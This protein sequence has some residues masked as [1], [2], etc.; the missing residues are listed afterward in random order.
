VIASLVDDGVFYEQLTAR[1]CCCLSNF[2]IVILNIVDHYISHEFIKHVSCISATV[3]LARTSKIKSAERIQSQ[4]D[5]F[6]IFAIYWLLNG[7][8]RDEVVVHPFWT[9]GRT[10]ILA[11]ENHAQ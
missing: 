3:I 9:S 8:G 11:T 10:E 2:R 7:Y 5:Q 1:E 4:C 6:T